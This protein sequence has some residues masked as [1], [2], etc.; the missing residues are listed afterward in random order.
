MGHTDVVPVNPDGWTRDP[1]GGELVDGEVWGRGAIDMLNITASM[2]VAFRQLARRGLPPGGHLVYFGVGRRGGRRRTG[3]PSTWSALGRGRRRLRADRVRGLVAATAVTAQHHRERRREGPGVAP[4]AVAGTPGHGSMP[5]G[6]DNALSRPPRS[7]AGW[8]PTGP[9]EPRRPVVG[10]RGL[11]RPPDPAAAL[12][13]P[14]SV[15]DAIA[16][17][18]APGP[19]GLVVLA[20]DV[21]RRTSST[22][23]R[24]P[25]DPDV[26][27]I[28][29]DIRTVPATATRSAATSTRPSA[30]C[31]TR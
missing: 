27:D 22:A 17:S 18:R 21:S 28:D 29:V 15:D 8:P 7:C 31:R 14:A 6:A 19:D 23:G 30:T 10:A 20:H 16:R 3:A 5:Y 26:V 11:D 1:F 4:A 25:T 9:A 13:D 12:L 24:R 2:A